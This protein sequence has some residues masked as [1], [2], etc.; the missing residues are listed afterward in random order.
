MRTEWP[1]R[2]IAEC[3]SDLPYSTQIGPFGKALT[4]S[5]YTVSGVPLLRG[6]N[7]NRGRFHDDDFVF[8][9][10]ET[11]DR[12]SK[13]ESFPDDVLLV[14]KGT[15]GQI[16]ILPKERR[17][18]RYLMGN[19]MLRVRCNPDILLPQF[20]YYWLS[21]DFGRGYL[22]SRVSQVG[23]PQIQRPLTTLRECPL[24]VPSIAEQRNITE[25]LDSLDTKIE[26]NQRTIAKLEELVRMTF[27]SWFVEFGPVRAKAAGATSYPG[28]P[29]ETFNQM[30]SD[31][32][33]SNSG[34]IP[35]GWTCESIA[36]LAVI[37]GG[38]TPKRSE[39]SFW[40]NG[41]PWYSVRDAPDDG[42]VWVTSPS[43]SITPTGLEKSSAKLLPEGGVIISARG[44]VGRLAMAGVPMAFNQSCYGLIAT[45]KSTRTS[46]HQAIQHAVA[47]LKQRT[48]GSVFD[49]IT[50][51]TLKSVELP[52]PPKSIVETFEQF[53]NPM[54]DSMRQHLIESHHLKGLRDYLLPKLMS[55]TTKAK[56]VGA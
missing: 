17:F 32:S 39:Q 34:A 20:L 42:Q 19:S 4:P 44:T 16:G 11:A 43:E 5:E 30:P 36:D 33:S 47:E 8:V 35:S 56:A 2:T 53:A 50:R 23:V 46:L 24:P 18:D 12:L 6:V 7:V 48:H 40:G 14:H 9:S 37:T 55:G 21:S 15:L 49:T 52:W 22:L 25:V 38:G 13:F 29:T 27:L 3:A 28:L 26:Q 10:D 51:D 41:V 45:E 54:Y 31:F 1:I